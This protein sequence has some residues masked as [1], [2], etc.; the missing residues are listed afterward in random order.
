[1]KTAIFAGGCFWGVEY[2]MLKCDGVESVASGYIG[3]NIDN[4]TYEQVKEGDTG[5]AEAVLITYDETKTDY[6]TLLKMFMEIHNPCQLNGQ[7]YD[8]GTQYRSEIYYQTEEEKEITLKVIDLL[9]SMGLDVVTKVTKAT[10]FYVAEDYHQNYY[11]I[12]GAL[13]DCHARV[14]RFK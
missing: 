11:N 6:E 2:Y 1:M 12:K 8:L 5:H 4:P 9:K 13:P 7:G 3:G 10:K 14:V